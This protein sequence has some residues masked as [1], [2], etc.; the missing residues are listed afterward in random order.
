MPEPLVFVGPVS[1]TQ[2][3]V[4]GV[5]G[6]LFETVAQAPVQGGLDAALRMRPERAARM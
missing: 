6:G 5:D 2:R 3:S 4:E 1:H